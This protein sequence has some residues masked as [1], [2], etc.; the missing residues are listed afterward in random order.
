MGRANSGGSSVLIR[1]YDIMTLIAA[2]TYKVPINTRHFVCRT[3]NHYKKSIYRY[4]ILSS[5][6]G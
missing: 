6:H 4:V 5:S 3:F 2:A 1:H